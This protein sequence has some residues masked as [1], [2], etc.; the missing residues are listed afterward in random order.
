MFVSSVIAAYDSL[1]Y[2]RCERWIHLYIYIYIYIL[3]THPHVVPVPF[4]FV[5]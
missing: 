3:F 2:P 5:T 4:V 1:S